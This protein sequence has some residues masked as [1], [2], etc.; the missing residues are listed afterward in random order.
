M[1]WIL[2]LPIAR[3]PIAFCYVFQPLWILLVTLLPIDR[4]GVSFFSAF[5]D[6]S[7]RLTVDADYI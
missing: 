3:V 5:L 4:A 7:L 6:Y 2:L 1:A